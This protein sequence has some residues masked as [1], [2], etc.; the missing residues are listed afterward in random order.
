M[1]IQNVL[2]DTIVRIIGFVIISGLFFLFFGSLMGSFS[3]AVV[4]AASGGMA[5]ATHHSRL[6]VRIWTKVMQIVGDDIAELVTSGKLV[7]GACAVAAC[8]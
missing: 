1:F 6:L 8:A 5:C 2:Q 7:L 3:E 4:I